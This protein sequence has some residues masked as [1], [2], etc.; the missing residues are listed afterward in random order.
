[1]MSPNQISENRRLAHSPPLRHT[2]LQ[3]IHVIGNFMRIWSVYT[4][5]HYLSQEGASVVVFIFSCLV[6]SAMFFLLSQK[7]WKGR[8][9]SSQQVIPTVLNG[10]I[11]ALYFILWAK[12]LKTCGPIRAI[13]GEYAGAV[14]GVLSAVLYGRKAHVWKK[15]GGLVA[16]S[17]AFYFLSQGWAMAT[18]SPFTFKDSLV[19]EGATKEALGM[20]EMTVPLCAGILS[21]LRRVV[22]R[23]VSLKN[24][25]KRRLHAVTM[26]SAACFLFPFAIWDLILGSSSDISIKLPISLWAYSS[27]ILF[28]IILIFYVD[29]IAEERLHMV[30]S[31]PRHLMVAGGCIIVMEIMYKMDFSLP[32]FLICST[33]LGFGIFEATSLERIKKDAPQPLDMSDGA[34]ETQN[35]GL[36]LPK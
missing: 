16:M 6:P 33:I 1:M 36:S 21:A 20:K 3:I 8:A 22:A 17:A 14:L 24:Q 26:A 15:V 4:M 34:F 29:N 30:F 10:G 2:P 5:Y 32:G 25:L 28:G 31:S 18:L 13:L 7:P 35:Q 11:T 27:V 9:L 23:R 19:T 12:G